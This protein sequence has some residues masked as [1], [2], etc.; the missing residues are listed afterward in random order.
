ML[1]ASISRAG[2]IVLLAG[3]AVAMLTGCDKVF[4][5]SAAR[6][7]DA[8]EEKEKAGDYKAAVQS[9]EAAIDGTPKSADVHYRLAMIYDDKLGNPLSAVH[10]F[11]RYLEIAPRGTHAKDARNF[12]SQDELKLGTSL[13]K[14]GMMSQSDAARLK[15]DNLEL[16]NQLVDA[17]KQITDLRSSLHDSLQHG[18]KA[19][20]IPQKPIPANAR[21]YTVEPGDTLASISRKFF[22]TTARARDIQD[23]NYNTLK[24]TVKIKPGQTLIIPAK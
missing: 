16:R 22:K 4:Q 7:L 14:G 8:A 12:I 3:S 18:G 24:G 13:S 9:Y 20:D 2:L 15:N 10:H 1:L 21:T 5:S 19:T 11:R 6:S 23:A 17:R